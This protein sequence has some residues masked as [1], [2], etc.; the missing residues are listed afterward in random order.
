MQRSIRSWMLVRT[1]F[2]L[3]LIPLPSFAQSATQP[4]HNIVL[5]HGAWADGSSWAK[6]IPLLEQKGYHVTAVQNPLTSFADDVAATKRVVD[7]QDGPVLLVGHSYGGAIIT[8]VGNNP[9]VAGLVYVAAF[10][11]DTGESAGGL[12]KPY[13][14][15]P[16]VTELRPLADGFLVLSDK[17]VQEDFAQDVPDSV[18]KL[19]IATQVP[20]QGAV[21]GATIS[22]AAWRT[23][24]SWFVIAANDRM[25][26]PEQER[27]SAKRMNARTLTLSSS[28]VPM[29]SKPAEVAAFLDDAARGTNNPKASGN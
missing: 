16:G 2:A 12:A 11:P 19:L 26:A 3:S 14:P 10:A 24:P 29:I 27:A 21:L 22:A 13:G 15:T 1:A 7:A 6:V 18:R 23:K 20:T 28:H 25:I 4:I 5:V 8:E 17:G 9:K